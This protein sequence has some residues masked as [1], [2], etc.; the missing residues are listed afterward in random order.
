MLKVYRM[1]EEVRMRLRSITIDC[2]LF[3]VDRGGEI[4]GG[5]TRVPD[6]LGFQSKR[7]ELR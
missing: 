5:Y 6:R 3:G 2:W 7:S 4:H 1:N